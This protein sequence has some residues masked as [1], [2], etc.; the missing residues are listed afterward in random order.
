M[1]YWTEE[2]VHLL[3]GCPDGCDEAKCHDKKLMEELKQM[4]PFE[5]R[6][7]MALEKLAYKIDDLEEIV[8][9]LAMIARCLDHF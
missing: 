1:P 9:K 5:R 3:S 2:D 6:H 7:I 4:T 8:E